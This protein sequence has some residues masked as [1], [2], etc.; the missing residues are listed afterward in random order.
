MAQIIWTGPALSELDAIADYIAL[1][2][3]SAAKRFVQRVLTSV[4][5]LADLPE[6][7]QRI[8]ELPK[9]LYRQLIV[10][11]CRIFYRHEAGKIFIIFVMRGERH[12]KE[13]FLKETPPM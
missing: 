11:P 5:R 7:G 4:E 2:K 10:T 8:P 6:S 9:S 3:P 1:D 12:F 13:E